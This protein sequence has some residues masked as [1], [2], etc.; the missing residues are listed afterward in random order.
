MPAITNRHEWIQDIQLPTNAVQYNLPTLGGNLPSDRFIHTL[1]LQFQGRLTNPATGNPTAVLADAPYSLIEEIRIGG[2]HKVR[3]QQ[4][5]F[6]RLRGADLRELTK[7]YQGSAPLSTP[8]GALATAANATN[9][10][11]FVVAVP[12]A[13]MWLPVS[14]QLPY[15]LDAPNYDNLRLT[16]IYGDTNSV[17]S[18]QTAPCV[19]SAYG[20]STGTPIVA[21]SA[22]F[23]MS[24]NLFRGYVPARVYRTYQ[25]VTSSVV[26]TGGTAQRLFNLPKG[27]KF[28]AGL[29]KAGIKATGTTG[30]FNAYASLSNSVLTNIQIN[31]GLNRYLRFFR[32]QYSLLN[33]NNSAFKIFPDTGYGLIDFV[34]Q[35]DASA[36]LDTS[37]WIS[38]P[39]GDTDFFFQADVLGAA[40]QAVLIVQEEWRYRAVQNK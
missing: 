23:A 2:Y 30:G 8:S 11:R 34:T 3:G 6:I 5:E 37:T 7:I 27:Y 29:I 9:D 32:D 22:D 15:I 31:R 26:T 33:V 36:V 16:V 19:F 35:G 20:A 17:F 24:P 40:N 28:R 13:P 18:G 25:E 4:E 14:Q 12:F 1:Y 21:V 38:G 10:I 39:T